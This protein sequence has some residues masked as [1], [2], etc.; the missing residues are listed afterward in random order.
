[1]KTQDAGY[2]RR[3]IT[4]ER[5]RIEALVR[6]LAPNVPEMRLEWLQEKQSR[7]DALKDSEL[8]K[9][10]KGRKGKGNQ[11]SLSSMRED[12]GEGKVGSQGKKTV[13]C[14]DSEQGENGLRSP[15][16]PNLQSH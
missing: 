16:S 9:R 8:L 10:N 3:Q 2:I 12:V 14:D 4:S 11:D 7:V 13:W 1:M 6:E 15:R 5:K